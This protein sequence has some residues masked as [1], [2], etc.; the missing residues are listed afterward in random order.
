LSAFQIVKERYIATR[1]Y[2]LL[3]SHT[4]RVEINKHICV[5]TQAQGCAVCNKCMEQFIT[6]NFLFRAKLVV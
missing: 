1:L 4:Q 5:N 2:S 3:L 6:N